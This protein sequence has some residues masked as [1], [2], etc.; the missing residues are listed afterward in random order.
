MPSRARSSSSVQEGVSFARHNAVWSTGVRM[1]S[2]VLTLD[3]IKPKVA[4]W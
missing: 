4:P 2:Q 1:F 3:W